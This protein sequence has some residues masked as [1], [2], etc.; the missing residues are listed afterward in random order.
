MLPAC[1]VIRSKDGAQGLHRR[2]SRAN[3]IAASVLALSQSSCMLVGYE[4]KQAT[5]RDDREG[6]V[7]GVVPGDGSDQPTGDSAVS[8]P[9]DSGA[10]H[11]DAARPDD[12]EH[13]ADTVDSGPASFPQPVADASA[14]TP[15]VVDAGGTTQVDAGGTTQ[16]DAGGMTAGCMGASA[17][18]LCWHLGAVGLSCDEACDTSYGGFD[19]R[20]I[21]YTGKP[22]E[23]A[24]TLANCQTV[25]LAL[26]ISTAPVA[27]YRADGLGLGC[28]L[29][30]NGAAYWLDQR[31]GPFDSGDSLYYVRRACACAH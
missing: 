28:H 21:Y 11:V 27:T 5:P 24:G 12:R 9:S 6:G 2:P 15:L 18:G 8:V 13:V 1:D 25:L 31:Q 3:L 19:V 29:F 7:I 20:T 26:G 30:A 14:P 10:T 22:S 4:N 17:L 23:G 16:V